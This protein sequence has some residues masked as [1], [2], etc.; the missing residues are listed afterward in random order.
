MHINAFLNHPFFQSS[1]LR[2]ALEEQGEQQTNHRES[3]SA[4]TNQDSVTKLNPASLKKVVND[5][6]VGAL[7]QAL[8]QTNAEPVYKMQS[9]DLIPDKIASRVLGFIAQ[10]LY[11]VERGSD[12]F[13]DKLAQAKHGI[14][15]GF[16]EAKDILTDL[17]VYNGNIE[18][19]AERTYDA[20][21]KGLDGLSTNQ[22]ETFHSRSVSTQQVVDIQVQTKDGDLVTIKV[23]NAYGEHGSLHMQHDANEFSLNHQ[24]S[25]YASE[26]L[27]YSIEGHLDDDE[28]EAIENLVGNINNVSASFFE[29]ETQTAFD[30]AQQLVFN[31]DELASYNMSMK[32]VQQTQVTSAYKEVEQFDKPVQA[33]SDLETSFKPFQNFLNGFTDAYSEVKNNTM[34]PDSDKT[35]FDLFTGLPRMNEDKLNHISQLEKSGKLFDDMVANLMGYTKSI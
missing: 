21:Q 3:T 7:E 18:E 27:S 9:E 29:G 1:N 34:I 19:N 35:F 26:K 17:G 30:L 15:K 28:I 12:V 16:N 4:T 11:G 23:N 6:I 2:Q 25:S 24:Q 20:L 5:K 14:E 32:E 10:A 31:D 22:V 13:N 8:S 33:S